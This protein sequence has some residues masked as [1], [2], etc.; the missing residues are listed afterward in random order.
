MQKGRKVKFPM[1]LF[2]GI[3]LAVVSAAC[4]LPISYARPQKHVF[5]PID[6]DDIFLALRDAARDEDGVKAEQLAARLFNYPLPSYVDYYRLKSH[7]RDASEQEI[8]D[9]LARY[10]GSAI[11]DRMRDRLAAR[12]G[13]AR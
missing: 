4:L 10:D 2:V 6:A 12:T 1:K 3:M 9:F 11:A 8:R 7:L 13:N 5:N